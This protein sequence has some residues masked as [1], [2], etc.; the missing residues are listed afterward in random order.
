MAD[1]SLQT[2]VTG[3]IFMAQCLKAEGVE[4]VFGQ[5][6]H[7]NY[8]LIDACDR[9]GIE[10]VSFR[11]EQQAVHAAD[12]YYRVS[13][14][15]A[16]INVHLSPG[17]TNTVTGVASAAMDG[18]PMLVITGNTPSY[19]HPREAHQS[20]RLHADA[21]QGDIF[22][23]ICKR[24]WRVDD[25]KF[26]PEVMHRALNI[27]Q[28]GRPGAVLLDIPMD[29]FS[30]KLEAMPATIARRPNF[31]RSQG[32]PVGVAEAVRLLAA[33]SHP[34]IFAGN[35]VALSQAQEALASLAEAAGI[36][37]ATTL[38]G[39]GV[40][41]E[42]SP[43]SLGVTG[44]WG[45]RVANDSCREAD[46]ILAVGTAFGE[47]DC[48][49]WRHEHTFDF[50]QT[51]L[52]Q[53]DIDPQEIG[54]SY[55]ADI[56]ILGDARAVLEQ[57][58]EG[59]KSTPRPQQTRANQAEQIVSAK[60]AWR[61][62]LKD[63]QLT[64]TKPIH[65]ARLLYELSRAAPDDA[66]F[67][68]DVGWNKNGAGQQLEIAGRNGFITS[69][70]MATMG[71]SPAAAVGAKMGA[72]DR[73]VLGLVGDGG[74]MSVLGALT[75][76]VELDIPVLWVLFN[77]FCYSTIRT[78]G[79]TYFNN[80][81]GTEFRTPDGELY[82]PDFQLLAKSFGIQSALIE[83]PEDLEAGIEAALAKNVPF[84]LEVRTRGDV[85]MPRTGYWDIADF[86]AHGND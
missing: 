29:V 22:R 7:T 68:T 17:L 73:K 49:S 50:D 56:G 85:P 79:T 77:N 65:P 6:G 30:Q 1:S 58:L 19:H 23:P 86:L 72:P 38:V 63:T 55:A 46:V 76:A 16:V 81:Q 34:V 13:K 59:L 48:S 61:E 60:A 14:K 54:K 43:L 10:Y 71:Y 21:S 67:V 37:V 26:L 25:A 8:A 18:T 3:A 28:T 69:G 20:M 42:T 35:G 5:C 15:L 47:A 52:I 2:S 62:E 45:T 31:P 27:C 4:K 53:I 40:F 36:P 33:A 57:L 32:D 66:I 44:I 84:L 51:T 83:E 11:H 9:L 82:N 75:T 78:V 74:L 64:D 41:P 70:G 80:Q 12:A 24:V 39:K